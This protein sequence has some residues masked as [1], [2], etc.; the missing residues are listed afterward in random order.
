MIIRLETDRNYLF[1]CRKLTSVRDIKEE[2][3]QLN[4]ENENSNH[5]HSTDNLAQ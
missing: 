4:Y 5:I 1:E 2:I 3:E